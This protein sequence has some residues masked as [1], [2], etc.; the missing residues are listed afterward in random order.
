[1]FE[2]RA[3]RAAEG[4][5][6]AVSASERG[7]DPLERFD[8]YRHT[9]RRNQRIRAGVLALGL[10]VAAVV[11]AVRSFGSNQRTRPATSPPVGLILYGEWNANL[12]Q[13]RWLTVRS[14]GSGVM[15]LGVVATCADWFPDARRILITDDAAVAAGQPLRPAVVNPDGTGRRALGAA[16][17]PHLNLGCG[18]V[19]PDAS[20]IVLEGFGR[21]G[22]QGI[23]SVRASDG[24]GLVRLT[25]S[26]DGYPRYSPDGGQVVFLR[27]K[28]GVTPSGAGALFVA[29]ADGTGARRIVPWGFA[30]L[31]YDW[32]P[33]GRWIAFE[34]PYGKLYLVHP[35][36]TGVHQIPL[37]LPPGTGAANPSWSPDGHWIAFALRRAGRSEIYAV[38]ADGTG[39]QKVVGPP[40]VEAQAP[41]WGGPPYEHP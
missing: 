20:R 23:Y 11:F 32:S 26:H 12:Q 27:T 37:R 39:L 8:R 34:R 6:R 3:R 25:H 17:D 30:F 29:N 7:V 35:D 9:K 24:G 13:A 2:D 14:D 41:D 18:D 15:N 4:V 31:F 16:T 19:S 5:R 36:G 10:A 40:G 28:A 33:D 1:M 38:H 21:R 22:M